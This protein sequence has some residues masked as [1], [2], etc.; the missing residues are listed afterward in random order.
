MLS[1]YAPSPGTR[2][3]AVDL[4]EQGAGLYGIISIRAG[5]RRC[6]DLAGVG[7]HPAV[8]SGPG[9]TR[10]RAMFLGQPFARTAQLHA[11]AV[12]QQVDAIGARL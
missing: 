10:P 7:I 3:Q 12:H 4:L 11:R 5:Q 2:R 8:Q 9:P 1:V 6:D